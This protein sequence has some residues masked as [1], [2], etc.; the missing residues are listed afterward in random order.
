MIVLDLAKTFERVGPFVVCVGVGYVFQILQ[1][2]FESVMWLLRGIR[3]GCRLKVLLQ[4]RFK[5]SQPSYKGQHGGL[6]LRIVLQD[7]LRAVTKVYPPMKMKGFV[8]DSTRRLKSRRKGAAKGSR[9]YLA[10]LDRGERNG[11]KLSLTA[12]G[13][14]GK[15]KVIVSCKFLE[16]NCKKTVRKKEWVWQT[17]QNR[18]EWTFAQGTSKLVA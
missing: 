13:K 4:N 3:K 16:R 12:E 10:E 8:D 2:D 5:L 9:A 11:L 7:A 18:W 15:S 14:K 6:L 17:A 1:E